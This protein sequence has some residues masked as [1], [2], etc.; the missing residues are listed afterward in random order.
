M[1]SIASTVS[2]SFLG[3]I[4]ALL[5]LAMLM[6]MLPAYGRYLVFPFVVVGWLISL[7]LHEFGHA[8]VAYRSG[9]RSVLDKGYLTLDP[10]RYTDLQY[11]IVW[12]LI[13]LAVG[14]VGL[15]GDAVYL[16]KHAIRSPVDRSLVSA[17]GPLANAAVLLLL[18]VILP[19]V[20]TT[21]SAPFYAG[22][23]FLAFLQLTSLVLTLLPIPGLDGWGIIEPW[24]PGEFQE[25]GARAAGIAPTL[26]FA[27]FLLVP[28][29]NGM[30]WRVVHDLANRINLDVLSAGFGLQLFQFWR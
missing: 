29:V 16:N 1:T 11:S 17:A 28:A 5:S 30:F 23:A 15:P 19:A 24:L 7:C 4:A 18:L 20:G 25:F 9:D 2:L 12:P 14:S 21:I 8:I 6:E 13:F 10:L 3:L 22:L 27:T 26:L